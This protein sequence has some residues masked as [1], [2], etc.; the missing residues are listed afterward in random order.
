VTSSIK[1]FRDEYLAHLNGL[2][3]PFR[4]SRARV[5]ATAGAH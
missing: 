2:G 3:C 1:F 4:P 5:L